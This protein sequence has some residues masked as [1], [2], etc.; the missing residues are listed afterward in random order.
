MRVRRHLRARPADG[1]G[2]AARRRLARSR[3]GSAAARGGADLGA[4]RR[5]R[6]QYGPAARALLRGRHGR[7]V[8]VA[9]SRSPRIRAGA[10]AVHQ[11]DAGRDRAAHGRERA[12]RLRGSP[13]GPVHVDAHH[14][15]PH[16]RPARQGAGDRGAAG[17]QAHLSQGRPRRSGGRRRR[18]WAL[19]RRA[20]A[21]RRLERPRWSG[22]G[23]QGQRPARGRPALGARAARAGAGAGQERAAHAR[24]AH[25]AARAAG[26]RRHTGEVAR[27]GGHGRGA[28]REDGRHPGDGRRARRAAFRLSRRQPR[29]VA[30]AR[31]HRPLRAGLDVQARDVHGRA[32]GGRDH[33]QHAVRRPVHLQQVRPHDR[34]RALPHPRRGLDG[35]RDPRA[36]LER[37]HDHDRRPEAR[38]DA[39]AQVD[40]PRRHRQADGRR[41]A[42]RAQGRP[43]RRRQVVRHRHPQRAD[44]RGHRRHASAD[45]GALRLGRQ[46]RH[47][48]PAARHGGHRRQARHRA[49]RSASSSRR[50]W[51]RSCA[52]C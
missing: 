43:A 34:G 18:R 16:A 49:G 44:R 12:V 24:P 15:G 10:L 41:S 39:A 33:A 1:A 35:S 52:A 36:L 42:G 47:V 21:Q 32:A 19:G 23:L 22:I 31:H 45:G 46:R 14:E 28:R 27:Q 38:R 17:A 9:R 30:A 37:R 51:P 3:G 25:P 7:R 13:R 50:T 20:L 4:A 2:A 29:R 40:P 48:D 6:R 11:C 8:A 26:D 5:D